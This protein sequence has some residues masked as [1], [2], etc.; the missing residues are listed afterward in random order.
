MKNKFTAKNPK[1]IQN[2]SNRN[3]PA[4]TPKASPIIYLKTNT[5]S[6]R[7][8]FEGSLSFVNAIV[9]FS[10]KLDFFLVIL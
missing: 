2:P 8:S 4:I 9:N 6:R 10:E 5:M 1:I 3:K 7:S